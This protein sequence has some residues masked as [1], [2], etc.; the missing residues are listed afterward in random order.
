MYGQPL[1]DWLVENDYQIS[2]VEKAA[3][4]NPPP[5]PVKPDFRTATDEE[6][7]A[8]RLAVVAYD[9]ARKAA[10]DLYH[11]GLRQQT[12]DLAAAGAELDLTFEIL[13]Y[14]YDSKAWQIKPVPANYTFTLVYQRITGWFKKVPVDA[15]EQI[16]YY[17][18]NRREPWT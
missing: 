17:S 6:K 7:K 10:G 8:Y 1:M 5:Q 13:T 12:A 3:D 9:I 4:F 15:Y 18:T 2:V 11:E 16:A 14:N